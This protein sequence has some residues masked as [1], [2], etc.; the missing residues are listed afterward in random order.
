MQTQLRIRAK[1]S[2]EPRIIPPFNIVNKGKQG[3]RYDKEQDQWHK[4]RE[5]I[6]LRSVINSRRMNEI[7]TY[8]GEIDMEGSFLSNRLIVSRH[9]GTRHILPAH[10]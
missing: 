2:V 10:A 6:K 9:L 5:G 3:S 4:I 1:D 8:L 7:S